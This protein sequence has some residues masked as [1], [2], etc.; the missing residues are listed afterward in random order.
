MHGLLEDSQLLMAVV[1][2]LLIWGGGGLDCAHGAVVC[3]A[4][5]ARRR[6]GPCSANRAVHRSGMRGLPS[7]CRVLCGLLMDG[8]RPGSVMG[9]CCA[10]KVRQPGEGLEILPWWTVH[11]QWEEMPPMVDRCLA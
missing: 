10:G 1:A 2:V 8:G 4:R 6:S 3:A 7:C 5:T 11:D 9:G